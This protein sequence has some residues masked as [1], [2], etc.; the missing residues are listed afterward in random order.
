M[1]EESQKEML[2]RVRAAQKKIQDKVEIKDKV[3]KKVTP[4][5]HPQ[6]GEVIDEERYKRSPKLKKYDDFL[7]DARKASTPEKK[8]NLVRKATDE[9][10]QLP[11][12]DKK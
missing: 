7:D 4:R 12:E 10:N 6:R 1:N 3:K 2:A 11:D 5:I 8:L 9:H